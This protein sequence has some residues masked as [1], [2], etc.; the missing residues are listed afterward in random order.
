MIKYQK[1]I[2]IILSLVE[3][4]K[5]IAMIELYIK[6]LISQAHFDGGREMLETVMHNLTKDNK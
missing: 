3:N 4:S 2:N 5:D 6:D 1:K